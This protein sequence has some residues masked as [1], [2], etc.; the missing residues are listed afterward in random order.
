MRDVWSHNREPKEL[1]I[2]SNNN[3]VTVLSN[4]T[5]IITLLID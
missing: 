3:K 1:E 2:E 4:L 5:V